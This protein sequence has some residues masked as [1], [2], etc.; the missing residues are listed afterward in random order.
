MIGKIDLML[1][2]SMYVRIYT[3]RISHHVF[4]IYTV[5]AVSEPLII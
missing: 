5:S 2:N 1:S 4:S 3:A